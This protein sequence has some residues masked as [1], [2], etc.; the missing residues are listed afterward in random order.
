MAREYIKSEGGTLVPIG[1]TQGLLIPISARGCIG[2]NTTPY[3]VPSGSYTPQYTFGTG[4]DWI[5]AGGIKVPKTGWYQ[6]SYNMVNNGSGSDRVIVYNLTKNGISQ[7]QSSEL[8]VNS[9][10][11]WSGYTNS[12]L[13]YCNK[14]DILRSTL[15]MQSGTDLHFKSSRLCVVLV[16]QQVP[17]IVANKGA[18]VS[19]G[20][21]QFDTDGH[22]FT[23]NY[24]DTETVVGRWIDGRPVYARTFQKTFSA[25]GPVM[26]ILDSCGNI[27]LIVDQNITYRSVSPWSVTGQI[28]YGGADTSNLGYIVQVTSNNYNINVWRNVV[29]TGYT[30][31]VYYITA[32]Y[33]KTTD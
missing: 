14:N 5:S 3:D 19:G 1:D 15:S 12:T 31:G 18:F 8:T 20:S 27:D 6:V 9:G 24:F 10:G 7:P 28:Y 29:N 30:T 33:V 13:V 21:F 11:D 17:D 16:E 4:E 23:K 22:G 25:T 32:Y 26:D 2:Q